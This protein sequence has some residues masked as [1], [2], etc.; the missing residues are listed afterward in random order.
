[1]FDPRYGTRSVT[2]RW[3]P[4]AAA[5]LLLLIQAAG[6]A[7]SKAEEPPVAAKVAG[8]PVYVAE[9][10]DLIA[11]T[12]AARRDQADVS[13]ELRAEALEQ[14]IHRRL[15]A[16]RLAQEGYSVSDE[17]A[18]GLLDDLKRRLAAQDLSLDDFMKRRGFTPAI[19]RRQ[20]AWDAMWGRYLASELT[21][22][23][24]EKYF[25]EHRRD[26]DGTELR[27]SHILFRVE[28]PADKD[29]V[30]DA[31][32]QARQVREQIAAGKLSFADAAA[33]FSSG[34][35]RRKGGDLGFIPRHDRMTEAFSRAAFEL[36][37]DQVS[38]PVTDQF[39]VHLICCTG[40][41]PGEKSWQDVR[42]AL[43]EAWA[44]ARFLELAQEQR[45][46]SRVEYTAVAPHFDPKTRALVPAKEP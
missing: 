45:K 40:V 33:K 2:S 21:D 37:V 39:G 4:S 7:A 9:V 34:P 20:L 3:L 32:R 38:P 13:P 27:V 29:Q 44:N 1:M 11:R 23:A 16:Q 19:L 30:G 24:L 46:Q 36:E 41:K 35:S 15:V 8:E 28:E 43:A 6:L 25:A 10:D 14:A 22:E 31:Q 42:R 18:G 17:D 12:R 5:S 26:Y